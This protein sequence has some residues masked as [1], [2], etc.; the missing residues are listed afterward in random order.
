MN[1]RYL[2]SPELRERLQR[3][4]SEVKAMKVKVSRLQKK[5]QKL[6]E[7]AGVTLGPD[8]HSD[9]RAILLDNDDN[10]SQLTPDSFA[11]IF[12]NQQKESM[13]KSPRQM[14]WHPMMIKWCIH[15]RMLSSSCYHSLRSS[16]VLALPSQRTLRDYTNVIKVKPG[17]QREVDEQLLEEANITSSRESYV[18]LIFDEVKVKED[19]VY[20][21]HS[22][23]LIGF[24]NITDINNHLLA[25]EK[26]CEDEENENKIQV[27]NY[28]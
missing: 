3:S 20:D 15:L 28:M 8:I 14:R 22:G 2:K 21:K 19:L 4:R 27:Y 26:A 12:W 6:T 11:Q 1:Y 25:L 5:L 23:E 9:L 17:F 18:A 24:V 16:G 13:L 10:V 7:S